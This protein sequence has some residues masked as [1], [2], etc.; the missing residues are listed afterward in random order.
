MVLHV[1]QLIACPC[2]KLYG[3]GRQAI[4]AMSACSEHH[5]ALD[6]ECHQLLMGLLLSWVAVQILANGLKGCLPMLA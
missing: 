1:R 4:L 6:M 5:Q 3:S 2:E